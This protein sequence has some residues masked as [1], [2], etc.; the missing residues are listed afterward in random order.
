MIFKNFSIFTLLF[1][2]MSSWVIAEDDSYCGDTSPSGISVDIESK[3]LVSV[4]RAFVFVDDRMG[5]KNA[6]IIAEE[7]AKN[8]MIRW[9]SQEQYTEREIVDSNAISGTTTQ[10]TD[11]SGKQTTNSVTR[12]MAQT[13]T[14][15]TR[16][17]AADILQGVQKFEESYDA[18]NLEVCVAM[19]TSPRSKEMVNEVKDWMNTKKKSSDNDSN[20]SDTQN[21]DTEE[22]TKPSSYHR[23]VKPI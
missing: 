5:I 12:E 14:E 20:D 1:M 10:L 21:A 18:D 11:S 15:F 16:S 9:F 22:S 3:T 7:G 2:T 19:A 4:F 17:T 6:V 8:Q 13:I 23:K